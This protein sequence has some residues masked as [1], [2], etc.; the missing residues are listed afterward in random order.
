MGLA[1]IYLNVIFP[2]PRHSKRRFSKKISLFATDRN[3]R[4]LLYSKNISLVSVPSQLN[5]VPTLIS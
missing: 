4:F 1:L 5:P 3:R 2:G